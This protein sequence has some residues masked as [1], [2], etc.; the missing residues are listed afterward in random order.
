MRLAERTDDS[1]SARGYDNSANTVM[2]SVII[3]FYSEVKAE[4]SDA[5]RHEFIVSMLSPLDLP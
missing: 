3:F 1:D 5:L 2:V 4:T